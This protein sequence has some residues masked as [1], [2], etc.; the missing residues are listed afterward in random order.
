MGKKGRKF[1]AK[2]EGQHFYVLRR[3]Q[4]DEA[5]AGEEKPSD[6]VL[7]ASNKKKVFV[8]VRSL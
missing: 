7:V 8:G 3:S 1:I 5:N 4:L 2:G 6:Y